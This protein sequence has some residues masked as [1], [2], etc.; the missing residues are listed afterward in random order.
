MTTGM[1]DRLASIATRRLRFDGYVLDLDRLCL[2]L[3]GVEIAL[4]PKTFA[5]LHFLAQNPTRLISKEELFA[6]VWPSLAIT[7]DV[8]VQSIGELRRALGDNGARLI[9]TVPRRGYRFEP[10]VI[11]EDLPA[12]GATGSPPRPASHDVI[13]SSPEQASDGGPPSDPERNRPAARSI[14]SAIPLVLLGIVAAALS[15]VVAARWEL[16]NV[17]APGLHAGTAR[18]A[19]EARPVLAVLPLVDQGDDPAQGYVAD[20]LTQDIINA[21]GRFSAMT[22]I[23]WNGVLP[24]KAKP[25]TPEQIGGNLGVDYLVEGSLARSGDRV[26][27]I[28]Q[29]VDTRRG[30]VLWSARLD[31]ALADVFALQDDIASRIAGALA[32]HVERVEQRRAF[33]K[34][35][36]NLAAYDDVLRARA[37]LQHPD[38]AGI[39][40]AR[41]LLKHAIELDPAYA[42]AYAALGETYYI[43]TSMGWAEAPVP[44]LS[45][46]EAL[47]N[48]ALSLS[49]GQV[50][51]HVTLGRIDIFYHR[52]HQAEAELDRAIE[53]NPNDADALAGRGNVL[54]WSG[55]TDAAIISLEQARRLDPDLG[56]MDRFALSLAYYLKGRYDA[57]IAEARLSLRQDSGANFSRVVLAAAYG[58][59]GDTDDA[60]HAA[61]AI[62]R[63]DPTFDPR[64][65][66]TKL[67]SAADLEHLRDGLREAGLYRADVAVRASGER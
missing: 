56:P 40:A 32:I 6:A 31:E 52:F 50:R 62:N 39:A 63:A 59:R 54:M 9:R 1:P 44:F 12:D 17:P 49:E 38:R 58:K 14:G 37:A 8:L 60:V 57:A 48:K 21:L 4:R 53:V 51:A 15:L 35:T 47:S 3:D 55:R 36:E 65:F 13:A 19:Q 45:R 41:L 66:G 7:D 43:A 2:L 29:L 10:V 27:V 33:A 23:S 67:L 20:G 24:Y 25:A 34:P 16:R 61:A 42:D 26:R 18:P 30:R 28:A 46:A 64:T 11:A 22:V 5:V